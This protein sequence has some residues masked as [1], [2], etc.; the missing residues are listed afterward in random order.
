MRIFADTGFY[1]ALLSTRDQHRTAAMAAAD[2]TIRD[3]IV[4][5][6]PVLVEVLAFMS[7]SGEQGRNRAVQFV[8]GLMTDDRTIIVPQTPEL[9]RAGLD[10]YRRR[11]DKSY[12]ATDCMSMAICDEHGITQILTH[13][14][15]FS[16]EGYEI[17]M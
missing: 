4:T 9:F 11:L 10:L 8:D 3:I 15:H 14:R 7:A 12:S 5:S 13:D 2:A 1:N 16:Q 6:E 17:L